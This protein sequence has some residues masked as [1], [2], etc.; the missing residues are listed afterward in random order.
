MNS[1][2]FPSIRSRDCRAGFTLTE[3]L[4]AGTI[5][6]LVTAAT[7]GTFLSG[8][9]MMYRNS[10]R[11]E[12]NA[13]LRYLLGH[14]TTNSMDS[15]EFLLLPNYSSLNGAVNLGVTW[16]GSS[17]AQPAADTFDSDLA[18]GDCLVLIKRLT[19]DP[20]SKIQRLRIYY[21]SSADTST[22]APILFFERNFGA[23]GTSDSPET[24]LNSISL[25]TT[26]TGGVRQLVTR[27]IGRRDPSTSTF[28]PIFS[29]ET[30][31]GTTPSFSS[32]ALNLE[33]IN[34]T[35]A[36]NMLSSSSFNYVISPRK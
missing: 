3:I 15:T 26:P 21:R 23:S 22:Q 34:G 1:S 33:V 13:S 35:T 5:A 8:L 17:L 4:I 24:I 30:P 29:A 25:P 9:R 16:P 28:L 20:S 32:V 7:L 10:Q 11:L 31:S 6:L 2:R 19:L 14:I 27:A 18:Q 12:T 36:N